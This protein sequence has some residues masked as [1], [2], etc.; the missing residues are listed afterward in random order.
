[1]RKIVINHCIGGFCL[2]KKVYKFL[3][4]KCDKFGLTIEW[5]IYTSNMGYETIYEKHR[6]LLKL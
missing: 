3:G 2:S 5:Y 1:M 4:L 6:V